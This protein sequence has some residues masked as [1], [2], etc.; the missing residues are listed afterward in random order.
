MRDDFS[1]EVKEALANRVAKRCSYPDCGAVTSGPQDDPR[2]AVNLGVAAHITGASPGGA[3]YDAAMTPEQRQDISNGIWFCQ[4]H[5]KLV[6]NDPTRFP[7]GLLQE[8]KAAAEEW[9]RANVGRTWGRRPQASTAN[10]TPAA[11]ESD[12]D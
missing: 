10:R 4:N 5:G 8:W 6:D 3:R 1:R 11:Q 7:A 9:A 12:W 2:K